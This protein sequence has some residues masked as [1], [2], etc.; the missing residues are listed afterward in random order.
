MS[1]YNCNYNCIA[2]AVSAIWVSHL[3]FFHFWKKIV[4]HLVANH[5]ELQLQSH[6]ILKTVELS[7]VVIELKFSLTLF[8]TFM[9]WWNSHFYAMMEFTLLCNDEKCEWEGENF[10]WFTCLNGKQ[11]KTNSGHYERQLILASFCLLTP[12]FISC[13]ASEW[14][15]F[16]L[17]P[18]RVWKKNSCRFDMCKIEKVH[19]FAG[20]NWSLG[21]MEKRYASEYLLFCLVSEG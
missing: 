8:H 12:L 18:Y 1:L 20:I 5:R 2:L 10:V 14:L 13:M 17:S 15:I 11:N 21:I 9:Q 19:R 16:P 7:Q 4:L 6:R 3:L